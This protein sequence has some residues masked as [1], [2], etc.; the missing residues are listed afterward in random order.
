MTYYNYNNNHYDE[1]NNNKLKLL[2]TILIILLSALSI[3]ALYQLYNKQYDTHVYL[4][5]PN[6]INQSDINQAAVEVYD[7]YI[8]YKNKN[9]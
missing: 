5:A 6:N 4:Y 9:Y 3:C 7:D 8:Y 2:I 1:N